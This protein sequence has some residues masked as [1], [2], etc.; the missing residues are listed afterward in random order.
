[1]KKRSGGALFTVVAVLF[2]VILI[3]PFLIYA[4]LRMGWPPLIG[5]LTAAQAMRSYAAGAHPEWE[6]KSVWAGYNLVN[7]EYFLDFTY[8]TLT[9][10]RNNGLWLV[11][12]ERR[13]NALRSDLG[14]GWRLKEGG[15]PSG[16]VRWSA[17]WRSGDSETPYITLRADFRSGQ[18]DPV[19]TEEEMRALMADHILEIYNRVAPAAAVDQV[20]VFYFHHAA[21]HE[22]GGIQWNSVTVDLPEGTALTREQILT[23]PLKTS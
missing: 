12:D 8:G 4:V 9:Y 15:E 20:S 1:M 14:V 22:K 17:G 6:A 3:A 23:A 21:D 19:P 5:N 18:G 10:D 11:R 13:E 7:D 16:D 2:A